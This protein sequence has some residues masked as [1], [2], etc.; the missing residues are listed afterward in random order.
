MKFLKK[1]IAALLSILIAL[2]FTF[3]R[4]EEIKS[5]GYAEGEIEASECTSEEI[6]TSENKNDNK[7]SILK[8]TIAGVVATVG[9]AAA[10]TAGI[11]ATGN[12]KI[13]GIK[14]IH[15]RDNLCWWIASVLCLYY[16]DDFKRNLENYKN[17]ARSNNQESLFNVLDDLENIFKELDECT[18]NVCQIT[19]NKEK[20]NEY[21][22]HLQ[23]YC[24]TRAC[25]NGK[26]LT[27][28]GFHVEFATYIGTGLRLNLNQSTYTDNNGNKYNVRLVFE[29]RHYY[30][31]LEPIKENCK[32]IIIGEKL[33][34]MYA[35]KLRNINVKLWH[36]ITYE[37][38]KPK[39]S[40]WSRL[41]RSLTKN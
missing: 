8:Y 4:A 7:S 1:S 12:N 34:D 37:R 14:A 18:G 6:E 25:E 38:I 41:K 26:K 35:I 30:V 9:T 24:G 28:P 10:V 16:S 13:P 21:R 23:A 22:E 40:L 39:L 36:G 27:D 2:N 5:S 29:S 17:R 3:C 20:M 19:K 15:W 33:C 32:G 31:Y 11:V